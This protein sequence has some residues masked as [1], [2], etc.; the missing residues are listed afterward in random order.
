MILTDFRD[1]ATDKQRGRFIG[2]PQ[3]VMKTLQAFKELASERLLQPC[4]GSPMGLRNSKSLSLQSYGS[5]S[6]MVVRED[7]GMGC[8]GG[9]LFPPVPG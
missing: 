8:G 3:T 4:Q 5:G 6:G 2:A 9:V 7:N 1:G